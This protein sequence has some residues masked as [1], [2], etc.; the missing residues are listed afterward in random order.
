M[1][2]NAQILLASFVAA[3]AFVGCAQV[4]PEG[5]ETLPSPSR[6]AAESPPLAPE[7]ALPPAEEPRASPALQV[8]GHRER[9][10]RALDL[11]QRGEWALALVQWKILRTLEPGNAEYAKQIGTTKAL[12]QNRVKGHVLAGEEAFRKRDLENAQREFLRALALDPLDT[13]PLRRLREID[14]QRT[15]SAEAVWLA[16][17]HPQGRRTAAGKD[18]PRTLPENRVSGAQ[19]RDYLETGIALYRQGKY[20]ASILEIEKYLNSFPNDSEAQEYVS[21]ARSKLQPTE[22]P[23][24][25][26]PAAREPQNTSSEQPGPTERPDSEGNSEEQRKAQAQE[27]YE[28]GLRIYRID[29][30]KAIEY[31]EH[32]LTLNPNHLQAKLQLERAYRMRKN[33]ERIQT[34]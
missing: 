17:L 3:L 20:E 28:Q 12:I 6:V 32:S 5:I 31:W 10:R 9:E 13:A 7:E 2:R 1:S 14:R 16:K 24:A 11:E 34:K 29:L 30:S 18:T 15:L 21:A 4:R 23:E 19:E 22:P 25:G 27:L 26:R 8:P 33:L